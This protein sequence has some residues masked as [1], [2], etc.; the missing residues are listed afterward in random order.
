MRAAALDTCG[1][2]GSSMTIVKTAEQ[3]VTSDGSE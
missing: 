1:P 2:A 3:K